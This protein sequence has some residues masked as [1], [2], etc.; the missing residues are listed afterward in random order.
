MPY[1]A[2]RLWWE[3][4]QRRP[5]REEIDAAADAF[6]R[7]NG[8]DDDDDD[9]SFDDEPAEPD[10]IAADVFG[11]ISRQAL[12]QARDNLDSAKTQYEQAVRQ[13]RANGWTW[14]EIGRIM[15]VSRQVLHKR[16]RNRP[17]D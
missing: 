7:A 11:G 4:Q 16:F 5:T 17:P 12:A 14:A 3:P 8:L 2:Q 10:P 9:W 13:A 15:G 6:R 1:P